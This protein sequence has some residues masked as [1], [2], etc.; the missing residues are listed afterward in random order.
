MDF[1]FATDVVVTFFCSFQNDDFTI[2]DDR[3]VIAKNYLS[4]WFTVDL[5]ACI[6]F[7]LLGTA[8]TSSGRDKAD[9]AKLRTNLKLIKLIK[10]LRILKIVK[11]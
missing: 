4:G 2:I 1:L 7:G 8:F 5:L 3:K 9:M 11:E 6:P 10:L